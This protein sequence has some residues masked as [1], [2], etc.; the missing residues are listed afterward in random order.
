YYGLHNGVAD[1]K[2]RTADGTRTISWLLTLREDPFGNQI[3]YNYLLDG[4]EPRL[5]SIHYDLDA[6]PSVP[7]VTAVILQYRERSDVNVAYVNGT[8]FRSSRLLTRIVIEST[9]YGGL[10]EYQ[11]DYA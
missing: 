2:V 10:H 1:G 5:A 11:L 6:D 9:V 7:H 8:L 4:N 3:K